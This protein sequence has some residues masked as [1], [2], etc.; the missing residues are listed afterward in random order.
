MEKLKRTRKHLQD[1]L[2]TALKDILRNNVTIHALESAKDMNFRDVILNVH[3]VE[4][5][6][7][8]LAA[9]TVLGNY[10]VEHRGFGPM[11]GPTERFTQDPSPCGEVEVGPHERDLE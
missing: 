8:A 7:K 4:R 3:L 9:A 2:A 10:R 5:L 11:E 1:E 6:S